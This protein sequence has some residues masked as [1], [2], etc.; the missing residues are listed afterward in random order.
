[1][2]DFRQV[3]A[4]AKSPYL[5]LGSSSGLK[6]YY[7]F[8]TGRNAM[9]RCG[10]SVGRF[11]QLGRVIIG[12]VVAEAA[13]EYRWRHERNH[14]RKR[15]RV[16]VVVAIIAVVTIGVTAAALAM[17][18]SLA[19]SPVTAGPNPTGSHSA[20]AKPTPSATPIA[21]PVAT[22]TQTQTPTP[23]PTPQPLP[24]ALPCE[25]EVLVTIWAHEDDDLI[26]ANPDI[27]NALAS[28][29]CVRT[30][31]LTAGDAG[32]GSSYWRSRE[33]GILRAYNEMRGSHAFWD[34]KKVFAASGAQLEILTRQ[35]DPGV[36]IAFLH[37]A[38]GGL[39]A[40][41][42]TSTGNVSLPLLLQGHVAS[43]TPL[44]GGPAVTAL[45]LQN[46]ITEAL[47][48][49][50]PSRVFTHIPAG[51]P[52]STGDHPDH[53]AA[54]SLVRNG[55]LAAKYPLSAVRYYVGYPSAQLPANMAPEVL[56]K[57]VDVYRT[58]AKEDPNITCADNKTCLERK[59]FGAWLQRSY[60]KT[61]EELDLP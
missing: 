30:L 19:S 25:G 7:E 32:Q 24:L 3:L 51:S 40:A 35:G 28:G 48:A 59:G 57:K 58:Y 11:S 26:F 60:A 38:D 55:V 42:F 8:R 46:T 43:M 17:L 36:S 27:N 14:A 9:I 29:G 41:G 33:L 12:G 61:D 53:G 1:M 45:T 31:F 56:A 22:Q 5:S 54:G 50:A 2:H 21:A 6:L 37:L 23:T 16:I 44:D 34:S 20:S 47:V 18:P 15:S 4:D 13:V 49:W 52:L 10:T 39:G